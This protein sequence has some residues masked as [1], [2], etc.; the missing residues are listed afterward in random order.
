MIRYKQIKNY[1]KKTQY[2]SGVKTFWQDQNNYTVINIIN[3]SNSINKAI[4]ISR[5]DSYSL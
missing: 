1:R 3:K 2:Y 4:S 5:F